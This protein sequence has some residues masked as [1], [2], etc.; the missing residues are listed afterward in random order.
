MIGPMEKM[1]NRPYEC[2]HCKHYISYQT[3]AAYDVIPMSIIDKGPESHNRVF[4][5]QKGD[6]VFEPVKPRNTK[7][8]YAL[9]D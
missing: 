1:I 3:C 2:E 9:E 8:I 4:P 6:Y 5:D 7:H